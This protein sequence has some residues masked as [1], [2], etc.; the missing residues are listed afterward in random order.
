MSE[1]IADW[2][3]PLV[4]TL[5]GVLGALGLSLIPLRAWTLLVK[6]RIWY[7]VSRHPGQL[8]LGLL[9]LGGI[10]VATAAAV[11]TLPRV[12]NCL[13]DMY[14]GPNKGSGMIALAILGIAVGIQELVW[15][16][17]GFG[18]HVVKRHAI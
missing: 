11:E 12:H 5:L 1:N 10:V 4:A 18:Q 13:M 14:C 6:H 3:V 7:P 15:L 9:A 16:L 8:A 2:L 17:A